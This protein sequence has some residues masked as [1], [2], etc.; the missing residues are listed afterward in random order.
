MLPP[1]T[2]CVYDVHEC[3]LHTQCIRDCDSTSI[4][5]HAV[6]DTQ[7]KEATKCNADYNRG[8]TKPL[9]TGISLG[10]PLTRRA[11]HTIV[12]LTTVLLITRGGVQLYIKLERTNTRI[13]YE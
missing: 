6:V 11:H 2:Q 10:D 9:I 3:Y 12:H 7:F 13:L 8:T 1:Y 4:K 5:K